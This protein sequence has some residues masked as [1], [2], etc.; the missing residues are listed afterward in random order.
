MVT[1]GTYRRLQ[2]ILTIFCVCVCFLSKLLSIILILVSLGKYWGFQSWDTLITGCSYRSGQ[3]NQA[4]PVIALHASRTIDW[5]WNKH[6]DLWRSPPWTIWIMDIRKKTVLSSLDREVQAYELRVS[7]N[8]LLS[9]R[10]KAAMQYERH[11]NMQSGIK[12]R[13]KTMFV[14]L[15]LAIC[16]CLQSTIGLPEREVSNSLCIFNVHGFGVTL[17][18]NI[19]SVD[20]PQED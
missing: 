17:S 1:F 15:D 4:R 11:T 2:K 20:E 7:R 9:H 10:K 5:P 12:I 13:R 16:P 19:D 18:Y 8:N 3:I 14:P 6:C